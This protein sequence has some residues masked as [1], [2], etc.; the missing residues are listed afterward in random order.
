M[1]A[2]GQRTTPAVRLGRDLP[3]LPLPPGRDRPRGGHPRGDVSRPILAG[4]GRRRGAQR[5]HR[6]RRVARD[7]R[8]QRDDVRGDRG[9]QRSSSAGPSCG[10]AA[11]T[12]SSRARSSIPGPSKPVPIYVA[13]AGPLNAKK[14]GKFADGMI[15]VGAADEK[16]EHA[17]GQVRRGRP[18]GRQ[19]P[20]RGA[21]A[22][23]D[24]R[25]LGADRRRGDRQRGPPLAERR[26]AVR[27]AGHQATPRTSRRWPRWSRPSTSRTGS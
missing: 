11:S 17:L 5:A 1:G 9:H 6:R 16:I 21:E 13:T 22:A 7:R 2:L 8:P 3:R 20:D 15:T 10:T 24:P 27:Q 12:S 14:T 4:P 25:L 23:P 18:R 26:N 19:G